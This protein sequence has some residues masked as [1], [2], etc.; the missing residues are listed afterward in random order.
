MSD[1]PISSKTAKRSIP[2]A[3]RRRWVDEPDITLSMQGDR[4]RFQFNVETSQERADLI[5]KALIEILGE[6]LQ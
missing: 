6:H 5:M 2:K 4:L 1:D 3:Q